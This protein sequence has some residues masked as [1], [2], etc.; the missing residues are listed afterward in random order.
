MVNIV[1]NQNSY[2]FTAS[3]L[4]N[5]GG[6]LANPPVSPGPSYGS[7]FFFLGNSSTILYPALNGLTLAAD[8]TM[9]VAAVQDDTFTFLANLIIAGSG[10]DT[11]YGTL[12]SVDLSANNGGLISG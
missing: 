12:N 1:G 3:G 8:P 2:T 9:S 4:T 5:P 10:A 6:S 7:H 11:I